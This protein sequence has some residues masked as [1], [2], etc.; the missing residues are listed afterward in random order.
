[1]RSYG[2]DYQKRLAAPQFEVEVEYLSRTLGSEAAAVN[3][4][5]P[6]EAVYCGRKMI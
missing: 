5:N 2:R 3:G 4:V 6:N 1:M